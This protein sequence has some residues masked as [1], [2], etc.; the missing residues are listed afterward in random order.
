MA[1]QNIFSDFRNFSKTYLHTSGTDVYEFQEDDYNCSINSQ[2]SNKLSESNSTKSSS[3]NASLVT[4]SS[5]PMLVE[6]ESEPSTQI[7][8]DNDSVTLEKETEIKYPFGYKKNAFEFIDTVCMTG[9]RVNTRVVLVTNG[10]E[11][12]HMYEFNAPL[13][14][15]S[16]TWRCNHSRKCKSRIYK[17]SNGKFVKCIKKFIDH[18]HALSTK[19][20]RKIKTRQAMKLVK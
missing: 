20:Q 19:Q 10:S 5:T 11:I 2:F 17:L 6:N 1:S 14:C 3:E 9:K 7:L 8:F 12:D 13:K 18:V 16:E 4:Q 15:G